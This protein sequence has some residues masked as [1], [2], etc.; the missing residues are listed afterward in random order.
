MQNLCLYLQWSKR[1]GPKMV[2][3]K[4]DLH[5]F[6]T[7]ISLLVLHIKIHEL[8]FFCK[9]SSAENNITKIFSAPA[10]VRLIPPQLQIPSLLF[11]RHNN[12]AARLIADWISTK[13]FHLHGLQTQN[14]KE[15]IAIYSKIYLISTWTTWQRPY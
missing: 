14:L 6:F 3:Q 8:I 1:L 2:T 4:V 13:C 15:N 12:L 5:I 9:N 11:F 7:I 10:K